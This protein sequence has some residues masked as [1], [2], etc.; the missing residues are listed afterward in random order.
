MYKER[1]LRAIP[2]VKMEQIKIYSKWNMAV[3][4]LTIFIKKNICKIKFTG[5][6]E[7]FYGRFSR[8]WANIQG[9]STAIITNQNGLRHHSILF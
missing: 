1:N 4:A 8:E 3:Y 6:S 7:L 5:E 2:S 9:T